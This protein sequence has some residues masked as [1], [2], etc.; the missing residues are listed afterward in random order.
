MEILSISSMVG[1]I[2]GIAQNVDKLSQFLTRL[3]NRKNCID[4]NYQIFQYTKPMCKDLEK[5]YEESNKP[6]F[7]K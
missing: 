5:I 7:I 3:Q 1:S 4:I 6:Y 2:E